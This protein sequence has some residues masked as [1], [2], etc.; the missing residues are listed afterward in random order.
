[1]VKST[2]KVFE[3][4]MEESDHRIDQPAVLRARLLDILV[5]DFDR[6]FGQWKWAT[7]DTGMGKLYLPIPRD[8][9]QAMFYSDGFLMKLISMQFFPFLKGFRYDIP[10]VNWLGESSRDFDRVFLTGLNATEWQKEISEVV[11]KL[12]DSVITAAIKKLPPEIYSISGPVLTKKLLSRRDL[13]KKEAMTY[14]RFISKNVNVIGSNQ[15]E[16]FK[17]TSIPEGLNVKVY[18]RKENNDT[19]FVMFNRTFDQKVT[20]EIRL[21][22]LNDDDLFDIDSTVNSR[23][24]I[25]VIGGRGNYTFNIKG[26]VQNY[27]YDMIDSN[28]YI[29][30]KKNSRVMFSKEPTVNYYNILGFKYDRSSF[31]GIVA[32]VNNDDGLLVGAGFSKKIFGFRNEPFTSFQR[33]TAMSALNRGGLQFRYSGEFNHVIRNLD[34]VVLSEA[35]TPGINNFFGLGNNTERDPTKPVTYY[36]VM[37][38]H[39]ET[40]L[41]FQKRFFETVKVLAGPVF[42]QYWNNPENNTGKVLE[43]PLLVGL[44]PKNVYQNKTYLGGKLA[45]QLNNL[46]NELFPTRGVKWNTELSSMAGLSKTSNNI[47]ELSSDM[48]LYASLSDPARLVTVIQLGAGHIFNDNYEYFQAFTLGAN[49]FLKGFRKNRF[50]GTST[51]YSSLEFRLKLT[52]IKSYILPGS[53]GIIGFNELGRVWLKKEASGRWHHSIGGGLYYVPFNL[54]IVSATVGFSQEEHLFN[55]S[56]GTRFNLSF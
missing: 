16:Y 24:R 25:R 5:A 8:R 28:N 43:N 1:K 21:Y 15:K 50:A 33:F 56:I 38:S 13:L 39:M 26:K 54:A 46:N 45:I 6:H 19:S 11:E 41:L 49:N 17:L 40:Q 51:F 32:A 42:Y 53:L 44:D 35:M 10:S 23:I 30:N 20:K 34:L 9:D 31:P 48:A 37:Y 36:R 27:L 7:G 18:G 14:Y 3:K 22:G 47:T 4:I 55:F 29:Q 52:D 2:N 12:N